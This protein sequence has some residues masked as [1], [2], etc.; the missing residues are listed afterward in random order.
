MSGVMKK[1]AILTI[2]AILLCSCDLMDSE[3]G[4]TYNYGEYAGYEYM[5]CVADNLIVDNLKQ[6]ETA[7]YVNSLSDAGSS[8]F[9][10]SG[11]LWNAG[12]K[13]TVTKK[14]GSLEGL[15]I[16]RAAAD[17]TWTLSR[18]GKYAFGYSY[19]KY[20]Y[21]NDDDDARYEYNTDY[22][23][24]VKML[25][26]TT[27]SARSDHFWWKVT[28][29]K[30]IRTEEKGYKAE[31]TTK[32]DA[33]LVYTYGTFCNWNFCDGVLLMKVYK[34]G[35]VVDFARLELTGAKSGSQ[36]IHNL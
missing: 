16:S 29:K 4:G 1:T 9:E 12:S 13:W 22:E 19:D 27:A 10:C 30:C 15:H 34:N 25:P 17:S 20:S 32:D 24:D 26:D 36:Y 8:R 3:W 28:L 6:M 11:D 31:L 14:G 5:I 35:D 7:L 2:A 33:P 23:M 18:N 21:Y